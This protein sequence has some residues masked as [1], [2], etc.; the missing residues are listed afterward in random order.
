MSHVWASIESLLYFLLL[1]GAFFLLMRFGRGAHVAG[2]GHAVRHGGETPGAGPPA[3]AIDPVCRTTVMTGEAKTSVHQGVIYYFCSSSCRES[4]EAGP[5][6]YL[7][8][9]Y[10]AS[11]PHQEEHHHD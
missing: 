10:A 2:H 5:A 1:A 4:F 7:G 6:S 8:K 11:A 3:S 9:R